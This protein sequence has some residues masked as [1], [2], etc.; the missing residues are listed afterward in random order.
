M[1]TKT[2]TKKA[3]K[4]RRRRCRNC[5][6][7]GDDVPADSRLC[8]E[9]EESYDYCQICDTWT[10]GHGHCLHVTWVDDPGVLAGCGSTHLDWEEHREDVLRLLG[11]FPG[12]AV[13]A[14]AALAKGRFTVRCG[15]YDRWC[16]LD[17][18]REVGAV[19]MDERRAVEADE[20]LEFAV[21]WV[22]SLDGPKTKAANALTVKWIDEWLK[23]RPKKGAT[24]P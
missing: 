23:R 21:A 6:E 14:R 17:G 22:R 16:L 13:V 15:W 7:L 19:P 18:G 12:L 3:A 8:R 10:Y 1:P 4:P 24:P 2:A 20:S 5:G 11:R 9:C